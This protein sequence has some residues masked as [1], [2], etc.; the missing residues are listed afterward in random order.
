MI[1]IGIRVLYEAAEESDADDVDDVGA[2][3]GNS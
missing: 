3:S 2:T 1:V